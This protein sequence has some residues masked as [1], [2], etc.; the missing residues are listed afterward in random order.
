[1]TTVKFCGLM[2]AEDAEIAVALGASHLGV[3]FATS[4]RQLTASKANVVLR[5]APPSVKRV[6][7]FATTTMR[8]ITAVTREIA[9]DVIQLHGAPCLSFIP[10]LREVFEGEIWSVVGVSRVE[11]AEKALQQA[12][13][14]ADAVLLDTAISGRTG[15][16]GIP[17]DWIGMGNA[18]SGLARRIPIVVAGGLNPG[19]VRD[20]IGS[21]RPDVVDV[22]SGVE[23]S[24]GIK[25]RNL[26]Q[27]FAE[28]VHSASMV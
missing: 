5:A 22:S 4:P 24:P 27:A 11:L 7:V 6:G 26:M 19:N 9:L 12:S 20:A 2:R 16:T 18:I 28:A 8:E 21:L 10:A 14:Y 1:M 15:G 25:D 17:F 3:I 13:E 23:V